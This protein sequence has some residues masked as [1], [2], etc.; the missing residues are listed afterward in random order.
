M[1]SSLDAIGRTEPWLTEKAIDFLDNYFISNPNAVVLEFGSGAST[2]WLSKRTENLYSIEHSPEYY[3][4]VNELLKGGGL[5][6]YRL[7]AKPYYNVC[8]EFD[9]EFFDL[10][11]VDGRNRKGCIY[12]SLSKLKPGGVLMLDNAE[13]TFYHAVFPL[14]D[15]WEYFSTE[16]RGPDKW[17]F[18]YT[19]WKTD[20][21]IKPISLGLH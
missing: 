20:W 14:M 7:V 2:V 19:G 10:I 18:W 17:G 5:V 16:Q 4:E 1:C 21:W 13:R 8:D 15:E 9:D 12:K 6:D 11:L 3:N